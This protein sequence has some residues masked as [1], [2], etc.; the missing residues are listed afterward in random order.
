MVYLIGFAPGF[1]Y[2]GGLPKQLATPRHAKPRM[3]VP[4]GSV[5]IAGE[6]TGIYPQSTPGGWNLIGCT[7]L[8]LFQPAANPPVLLQPGDEVRFKAISPEEFAKLKGAL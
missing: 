8:K 1:P 2:L 6:Q 3:A 4:P 7:P 5:G